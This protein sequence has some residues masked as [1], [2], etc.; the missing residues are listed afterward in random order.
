[1]K[2]QVILFGA[3]GSGKGSQAKYLVKEY[4]FKHLSTGDILRAEVKK[5]TDLG[6]RIAGRIEK[7]ELVSDEIILELLQANL[8]LDN[9]SY[10]FD[11]Y[12]RNL[13]QAQIL[14]E[15]L[16]ANYNVIAIYFD[17]DVRVLTKRIVN[18]LVCPDCQAIYNRI[19]HPPKLGAVCDYCH[20]Q[21]YQRA[22]DNEETVVSRMKIFQEVTSPVLDFFKEKGTLHTMNAADDFDNIR[23]RIK[24]VLDNV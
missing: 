5:G 13:S 6:V 8:D 19:S 17:I 16:L 1:M 14:C 22:D 3:P 11:G 24:K 12:P 18:R 9:N 4:G 10:I 7:G 15:K 20:G 23:E 2:K 21:I